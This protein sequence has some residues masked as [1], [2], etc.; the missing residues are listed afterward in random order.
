MSDKKT[1]L[2]TRFSKATDNF[3]ID[4]REETIKAG[5]EL[6]PELIE[7]LYKRLES[8]LDDLAD[9]LIEKAES[10]LRKKARKIKR[11]WRKI[12]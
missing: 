1:E 6:P 3:I 7:Y 12:W 10:W 11:W 4:V 9:E 5:I 2:I 8:M